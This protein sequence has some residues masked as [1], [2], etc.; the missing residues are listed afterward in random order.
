MATAPETLGVVWREEAVL[1]VFNDNK[2]GGRGG[3]TNV[4]MRSPTRTIVSILF[5]ELRTRSASQVTEPGGKAAMIVEP[6]RG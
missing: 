6:L 5:D 4:P 2:L 1:T 3:Q